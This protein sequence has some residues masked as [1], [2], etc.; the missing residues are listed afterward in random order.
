MTEAKTGAADHRMLPQIR[1]FYG[2]KNKN[3]FYSTDRGL[4]SNT[5]LAQE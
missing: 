5:L 3:P 1:A 2:P 4:R